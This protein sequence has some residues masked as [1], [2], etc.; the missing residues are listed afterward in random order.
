GSHTARWV[1]A[2]ARKDLV[3]VAF[4]AEEKGDKAAQWWIDRLE[5]AHRLRPWWADANQM[6]QDGIDLLNR[7]ILPCIHSIQA[8]QI[9]IPEGCEVCAVCLDLGKETPAP[10]EA[11]SLMYCAE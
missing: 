1:A 10:Y 2:L 11:D 3:L 5:N 9:V 4:D 8:S 6:L 7:W